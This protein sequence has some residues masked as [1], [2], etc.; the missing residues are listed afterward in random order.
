MTMEAQ[1]VSALYRALRRLASRIIA[2]DPGQQQKA[3][4]SNIESEICWQVV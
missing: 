1:G 4:H 2:I 3:N